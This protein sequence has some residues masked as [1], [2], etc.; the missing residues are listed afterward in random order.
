MGPLFGKTAAYIPLRRLTA[1]LRRPF[2]IF[3]RPL[4]LSLLASL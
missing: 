1:A 2:V 3:E 4:M